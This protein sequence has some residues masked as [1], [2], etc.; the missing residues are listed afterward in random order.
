MARFI[1]HLVL[2]CALA[3]QPVSPTNCRSAHVQ[4]ECC[5]LSG[6]CGEASACDC[7]PRE[8]RTPSPK[9]DRNDV[10]RL[11]LAVMP[12][13]IETALTTWTPGSPGAVVHAGPRSVASVRA[14]LCVWLT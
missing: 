7:G 4:D 14:A 2:A 3:L 5:C 12:E 6:A 9:R 13:R 1:F 11:S 10:P 8:Q